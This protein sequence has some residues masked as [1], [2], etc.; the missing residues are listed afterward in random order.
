MAAPVQRA[1]R[2]KY[3]K[4]P[5]TDKTI[6]AWY[7]K[8]T[9][10]GCLCKQKS[11]GHPLTAE[12]DVERVRASFLHSPK[13]STETAAKELSMSNT[14]VWRVLRTRLVFKPSRIQITVC[15]HGEHYETPCIQVTFHFKNYVMI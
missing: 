14:T 9:E 7:K 5:S 6:R 15:N 8:F 1:F 10:T 4:D 12:D 3:A 11:S 2:A 13:K